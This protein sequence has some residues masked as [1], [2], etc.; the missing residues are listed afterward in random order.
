MKL[1][2]AI[3]IFNNEYGILFIYKKNTVEK[4]GRRVV[5]KYKLVSCPIQEE[6]YNCPLFVWVEYGV[7]D[8]KE[9]KCPILK[10]NCKFNSRPNDC[11]LQEAKEYDH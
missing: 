11:P 9:Y 1:R 6:E 10:K 4:A 2:Q 5:K 8:P 7:V 3:K